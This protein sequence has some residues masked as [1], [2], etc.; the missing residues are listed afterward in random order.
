MILVTT[1]GKVG[2]HAAR[3][4][5]VAGHP[6]RLLVRDPAAHEGLRAIGV[7]VF[8]GDLDRAGSVTAA[9]SGVTSVV[10][11]TAPAA[12]QELTVVAAARTA[13]VEHVT[14]ITA[15]A[16]ADSPIARRRAHHRVEQAL[17]ASG[18]PHTLLRAN[19][20][21]QNVLALAPSVAATD[22]FA[23]AAGDGRIGMVDARDVAAVAAAVAASPGEHAGRTYRL[24]GAETL[25]YD[26]V[27]TGL[28]QVL[29][30]TVT[31]GR[32]TVG[33]QAAAMVRAGLAPAV[34]EDNSR[35]LEL[36]AAGDADWTSPHVAEVLHRPPTSFAQ[37]L[38]EH[39]DRFGAPGR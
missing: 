1:A 22:T 38:A 21:L 35:A 3:T 8:P 12:D 34:A 29:G 25:S 24:S 17:A 32:L 16:S 36:F 30:R 19:A 15:D 31:H 6:V 4:L 7:E 23:T 37:F 27:A 26:D 2:A 14:K 11:V 10:L 5:A 28:S 13:G 20:Y 39:V 9:L 18:I 33:E